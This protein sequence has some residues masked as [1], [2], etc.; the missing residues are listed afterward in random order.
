MDELITFRDIIKKS[1]LNLE[2]FANVS[3]VDMCWGLL[4][5]FAVGMFIYY[6]YRVCYRGVV[7]SHNYNV[8][9]VLMT[10]ITALIIMTIS[11]NI[12]LSLGM[13]GALSIVRFRTAVKDPMD[14]VYMFWAVSAGIAA[15]A[16]I[17]PVAIFGSLVVGGT[18][19]WLS[20]RKEATSPY[21][22]ILHYEAIAEEEVKRRIRKMNAV[23]K[24]KTVRKE[25]T[26]LTVELR[27]RDDNTAFVN[28]FSALEG[29]KDVVLV[30]YNGE[31]AQ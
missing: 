19:W 20:R 27:I 21:L 30:S 12:V 24:S 8:T 16:K 13:V 25:L 3:W 2:A 22:L 1:V 14:I 11:T 23:L 18:I 15:G 4:V 28:D 29:V 31:Y 26:E 6:V 9:F 10:I 17:Y 7:Y 5:A